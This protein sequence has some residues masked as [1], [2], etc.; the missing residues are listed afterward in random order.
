MF[1]DSDIKITIY[2]N[3]NYNV[4]YNDIKFNKNIEP[5]IYKGSLTTITIN[6]ITKI[7]TY[8]QIDN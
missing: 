3:K 6:S 1:D 8:I 2:G 7:A 5:I 4:I